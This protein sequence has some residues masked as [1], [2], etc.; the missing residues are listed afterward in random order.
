MRNSNNSAAS[1]RPDPLVETP[2]LGVSKDEA[3]NSAL[4]EF[5]LLLDQQRKE[6]ADNDT[7]L[8]ALKFSTRE[9]TVSTVPGNKLT[10][11]PTFKTVEPW[12]LQFTTNPHLQVMENIAPESRQAIEYEAHMRGLAAED[13]WTKFSDPEILLLVK[14]CFSQQSEGQE[15]SATQYVEMMKSNAHSFFPGEK[16]S[17]R[18]LQ[19][20]INFCDLLSNEKVS[21]V[22]LQKEWI[23]HIWDKIPKNMKIKSFLKDAMN[24]CTTLKAFIYLIGK[25]N[26]TTNQQNNP[27]IDNGFIDT[28]DPRFRFHYSASSER[29]GS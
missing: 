16:G 4:A 18:F 12:L 6:L 29:R 14:A 2:P 17:A 24:V 19:H 13:N 26:H 22:I 11:I 27:V 23:Y 21:N 25:Y 10:E 7:A 9:I 28:T 20:S 1:G 5:Q 8:E 15:L 3:A